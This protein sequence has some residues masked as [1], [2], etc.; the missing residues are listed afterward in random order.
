MREFFLENATSVIPSFSNYTLLV[1]GDLMIDEYLWGRVDRISPEAPVQVVDIENQTYVLGGAGNVVNNL[2]SLGA[3]V[4]VT[5]VIGQDINGE[6]LH[7]E[8]KRLGVT[9]EG[10]FFD[11]ARRT[12]KKTRVMAHGQQVLR[13]DWET[14][15]EVLEGLGDRIINYVRDNVSLFDVVLISDYA[16]GV[17][18]GKVL[19][20]VIHACHNGKKPVLA[21]PKG[22]EFKNYKGA[23]IITANKKEAALAS[24][25][26]IENEDA[27]IHI[28]QGFVHE[29]ELE[30]ALITRGKEGMTLFMKGK[31]PVHIKAQVR[32]VY[33]VS[34]AGDT[35][36]AVLGL[37]IA[38]GL[39]FTHA[40]YLANLAAGIVVSKIGT[41][42]TSR[43]ELMDALVQ[44][45]AFTTNK[46]KNLQELK[47][48]V[49]YL[50]AQGK[51][52]V[53]TNGC[54]DL[55]HVGHIK[56][57]KES[58]ALGD[59]LIVALDSDDSVRRLKGNGRPIINQYERAK[60]L[61]AL[62]CVD[63]ITIFSTDSLCDLLR[64]LSPGVLT[65]GS[66][67]KKEEVIGREIVEGYGGEVVLIPVAEG[68]STSEIIGNIVKNQI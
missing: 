2:V 22:N 46:V 25:I 26:P 62:D 21:G 29:L 9:T 16:K 47:Q 33:D 8:L 15:K 48:I 10:L 64:E 24:G 13:I 35:V 30:A 27:L 14:R 59:I 60:V 19:K 57:L 31:P 58:K 61:A 39:S 40:S 23:T 4:Y 1:V 6:L 66:N 53:F 55:L 20:G 12:T 11:A 7:H 45:I 56:L 36:L 67:Y 49:G 51:R 17:L 28:G 5:G 43:D 65:K 42:T 54:F 32:E 50:K 37:G 3:K 38:S 63:Y 44:R 34:G 68:I 41:A 52:V 18:T